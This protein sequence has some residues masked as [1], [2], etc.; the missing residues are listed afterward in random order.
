M[1]T[2][3]NDLVVNS[4]DD[5]T[6]T[7]TEETTS[8]TE[9][10]AEQADSSGADAI[11]L[12]RAE[13]EERERAIRKDQD[14]RWK[15]RIKGFDSVKSGQEGSK[16][17]NEEVATKEELD[18]FRLEAKGIEDKAAQDFIL[19]FARLENLPVSDALK[20]DYVQA[21]LS[22]LTADSEKARAT[23]S[24]VNRTGRPREK[25][26]EELARAMEKGQIPQ[27]KEER[28][29]ALKALQS[30]YGRTS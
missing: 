8:Q 19:K 4:S 26:P 17:G 9:L 20:D 22:R 3:N 29:I 15:D 6:L 11:T 2:D 30:R 23:Q 7:E 21:K 28:K 12:S 14:K 27:S 1:S 10:E 13:L 25:T 18:R 24:P 16:K 5:E